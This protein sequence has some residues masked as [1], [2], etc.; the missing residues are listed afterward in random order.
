[1]VIDQ[2]AADS[3]KKNEGQGSEELGLET[4]RKSP[5]SKKSLKD[6][7]KKKGLEGELIRKAQGGQNLDINDLSRSSSN[8]S[9]KNLSGSN[10]K[11]KDV[12]A[13]GLI[14]SPKP[15]G[16]NSTSGEIVTRDTDAAVS[17]SADPK[18]SGSNLTEGDWTE[19]LSVPGKK[20]PS[21]VN[22]GSSAVL[23]TRGARRG[24]SG[25]GTNLSSL[26]GKSGQKASNGD[27]KNL[28]KA[29]KQ[30]E[31]K[32]K[33]SGL[34][35]RSGSG[36]VTPRTSS[37]DL[38]SDGENQRGDSNGEDKGEKVNS[39]GKDAEIKGEGVVFASSVDRQVKLSKDDF[40]GGTHPKMKAST[41]S[42]S[43]LDLKKGKKDNKILNSS[44]N[45]VDSSALE[46]RSSTSTKR[47]S[48]STSNEQSGSDTDYSTSSSDSESER[49]R[50]ERRKRR[51]HIL[52]EKAAA[53]AVEAI[54]E[55]E[56]TIARLEGEKQSLEKILEVREKQQVQEASELQSTMMEVMEAV[57]LEKQK[58]NN[59]RMEAL[60]RLA[61]LEKTNAD[62]ARSLATVQWNLGVEVNRVSELRQQIELKEATHEDF[63]RKISSTQRT[64]DKLK[65]PKGIELEREILE[66]EYSLLTDKVGRLEDKAKTLESSIESTLREL[67]NPTE[68][69]VELKR[70]LGQLTDHLIQ[71][72]AQVEALSSEKATLMF[73]I[74]GT[75]R[76]LDE[77]KAMDSAIFPS[78]SSR[79]LETGLLDLSS[80][81]LRPM[82][83]ERIRSGRQHFG[84]IVRQLDSI[85]CA[86]AIFLKRNSAARI[87]S[88]VYLG[89]LHIWVMYILSS[90]SPVSDEARSGAVISLQNINNTGG[91]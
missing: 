26:N 11:D 65:P 25:S 67:E 55:R 56:N 24:N 57:D 66:A 69:E 9:I 38:R 13:S 17:V 64:D 6:Q 51:Q 68:V 28:R 50:E 61:K 15:S 86:G 18:A 3:L 4:K 34:D 83:E 31:S 70:R 90:H 52:A 37:V 14:L 73:K 29:G 84:S 41:I 21:G 78:T 8:S 82:F 77:N 88:L 85:Y 10:N 1:M 81:K 49:E 63:R 27:L 62:L 20:E 47:G 80:S 87:W 12:A 42:D 40:V 72:Q 75:S 7:L 2:Q 45:M 19:L 23:G 54:K 5:G 30:L 74:E 39:V 59:T 43:K 76:L 22:R 60:T 33:G 53:K 89:C 32:A 79:D 48:S 35:G 91:V 36:E 16:S 58:H 71:K 46:S 44:M